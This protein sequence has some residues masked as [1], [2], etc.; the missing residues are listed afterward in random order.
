VDIAQAGAVREQR[1][2]RPSG[3]EG[4]ERGEHRFDA[5]QAELCV[6]GAEP[7]SRAVDLK[8][9]VAGR[10]GEIESYEAITAR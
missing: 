4:P 3:T 8:T 7:E 6:L 2:P 1:L 9:V 5:G 10:P